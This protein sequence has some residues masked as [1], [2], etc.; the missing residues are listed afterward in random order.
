MLPSTL[1]I[2]KFDYILLIQPLINKQ[3]KEAASPR[4]Y[5]LVV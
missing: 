4:A 1:Q 3:H 2:L 5:G